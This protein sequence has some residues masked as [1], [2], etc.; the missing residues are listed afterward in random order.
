[1]RDPI[2]KRMGLYHKFNVE[3]TDVKHLPGEKHD[4]CA[5][6]V[7]DITHD[8]HAIPALSAYAD[9]CKAD[10]PL[11]ARDIW[12]KLEERKEGKVI[13]YER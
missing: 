9:S 10:F 13:D 8:P 1:M 2:D 5:Y 3:R 12:I 4:R 6:F 7:L 11:L